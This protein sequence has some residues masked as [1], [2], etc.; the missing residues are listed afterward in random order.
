MSLA[1]SVLK[2]QFEI[3]KEAVCIAA[4]KLLAF[5]AWTLSLPGQ[6]YEALPGRKDNHCHF[7]FAFK[8]YLLSSS[9][10]SISEAL[11]F[12]FCRYS[13]LYNAAHEILLVLLCMELYYLH[14][15]DVACIVLIRLIIYSLSL[16]VGHTELKV[17]AFWLIF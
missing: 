13:D 15:Y 10:F 2:V 1:A 7:C 6:F 14:M 4:S 3:W 12:I 17:S 5:D 9:V 11:K 16:F 8:Y